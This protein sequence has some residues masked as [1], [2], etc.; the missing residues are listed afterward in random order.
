MAD[1]LDFFGERWDFVLI[2]DVRFPNELMRLRERG[3]EVEYL[4]VER[5]G[6]N[7]GLTTAQKAHTSETAMDYIQPD[8]VILNSGSLDYLEQAV[9][10]WTEEHIYGK[11]ETV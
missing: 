9:K 8:S 5:P 10:I 7:N 11:E 2:P 1:T 6:Y 3:F 4:R